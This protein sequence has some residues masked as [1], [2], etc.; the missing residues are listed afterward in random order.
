M[1]GGR[2][3]RRSAPVCDV[4]AQ[5]ERQIRRVA[6]RA[7]APAEATRVAATFRLLGHPTRVRIVDALRHS[8]LCVCDLSVLLDMKISTISHQLA[9]LKQHNMV[10]GRRDGKMI[11]YSLDDRHVRALYDQCLE[12]HRHAPGR[13]ARP[14]SKER[15]G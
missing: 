3:T 7:A 9:L 10:R 14:A 8:D 6:A 15:P 12:H 4:F 13:S 2:A 5:D 11:H 1:T